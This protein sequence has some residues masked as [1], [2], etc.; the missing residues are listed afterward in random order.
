MALAQQGDQ[1]L[2]ESFP[3]ADDHGADCGADT[4]HRPGNRRVFDHGASP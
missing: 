3:M 2:L 1:K 4:M